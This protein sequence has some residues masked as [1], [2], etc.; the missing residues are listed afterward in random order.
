M[1]NSFPGTSARVNILPDAKDEGTLKV[2]CA[3]SI[4]I[5]RRM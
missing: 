5:G 1:D 4:G 2:L 3:Q